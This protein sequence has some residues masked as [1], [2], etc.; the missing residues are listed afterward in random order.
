MGKQGVSKNDGDLV[1][2]FFHSLNKHLLSTYCVPGCV[3]GIGE[4]T[5]N[6]RDKVL[7]FWSLPSHRE[8]DNEEFNK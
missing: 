4:T 8:V 5:E 1:N 3:L 7:A 2:T 6:E